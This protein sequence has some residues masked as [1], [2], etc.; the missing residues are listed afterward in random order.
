MLLFVA[1][2]MEERS[3]DPAKEELV[4]PK[5]P[6]IHNKPENDNDQGSK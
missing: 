3:H 4:M 5:M 2:S 6:V 1:I